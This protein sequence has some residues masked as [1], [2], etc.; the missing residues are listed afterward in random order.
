MYAEATLRTIKFFRVRSRQIIA[1]S[2][3]PSS[4]ASAEIRTVIHKPPRMV[5]QDPF[6]IRI[7]YSLSDKVKIYHYP[8]C[9]ESLF[10]SS[11]AIS[12]VRVKHYYYTGRKGAESRR[13]VAQVSFTR[14]SS[15]RCH[16]CSE[17]LKYSLAKLAQILVGTWLKFSLTF[18]KVFL[19]KISEFQMVH[20]FGTSGGV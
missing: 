17:W 18:T 19:T 1:P 7:T 3:V 11:I 6:L 4:S 13:G 12:C 20:R 8:S 9:A 14:G 2:N 15:I 16:F 10:S 5:F